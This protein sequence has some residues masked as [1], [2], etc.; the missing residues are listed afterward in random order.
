[1]VKNTNYMVSM[2]TVVTLLQSK[3]VLQLP[4]KADGVMTG[5]LYAD[6]MNTPYGS[7][8]ARIVN[9]AVNLLEDPSTP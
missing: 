8:L 9:V 6:T 4:V 2:E 5:W 3:K 7:S 1:V